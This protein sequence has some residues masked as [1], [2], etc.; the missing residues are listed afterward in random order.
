MPAQHYSLSKFASTASVEKAVTDLLDSK[1][2]AIH[3]RSSIEVSILCPF[4]DNRNSP[5]LYININTG[6]WQCFNP[7][8]GSKGNFRQLYRSLTGKA[9]G[10]E[11]LLDPI[12][13]QRELD[14]AL[15]EEKEQELTID[16]T[17]VDYEN[18]LGL[19]QSMTDRGYTADTLKYFEIGYSRVKDRIVI[20]VRDS[21]YKLVGIIGRAIHDWQDPKYLYNKGFRRG[22]L[23]FNIQNAKKYDQVIV[24]EGSLD[25]VKVHQ[26]GYPNVVATLGA[27]VTSYQL[28]L[29]RRYF[30]SLIIFSDADSA[31]DEM[32]S[33]ILDGCRGK[34]VY[35]MKIPD[36]LKD[37]GDMTEDQIDHSFN[38]KTLSH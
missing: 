36:G 18:E 38:T 12:N 5:S 6:L 11:W 28:K 35:V 26:S 1:G 4:H 27:K 17:R 13:L 30:D 7:S 25:A 31:G 21:Q 22:D 16:G 34:E 19:V 15:I 2:I 14:N 10:K 32:K 8:C 24:C 37:P 3:N 23:L 33:A 29:L 20:P 9:Y